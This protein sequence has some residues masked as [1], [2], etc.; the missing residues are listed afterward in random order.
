MIQEVECVGK[1]DQFLVSNSSHPTA[2]P[3]PQKTEICVPKLRL[4]SGIDKGSQ[5]NLLLLKKYYLKKLISSKGES[6]N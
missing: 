1:I 2:A 4:N 5:E 3:P 6:H